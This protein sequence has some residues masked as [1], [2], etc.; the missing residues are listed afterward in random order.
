MDERPFSLLSRAIARS[1]QTYLSLEPIFRNLPGMEESRQVRK[2]SGV[3]GAGIQGS[4]RLGTLLTSLREPNL[5]R[6][7]PPLPAHLHQSPGRPALT[8]AASWPRSG[9]FCLKERNEVSL[10][11]RPSLPWRPQ[12]RSPSSP[13][14]ASAASCPP[15][16]PQ[17]TVSLYIWLDHKRS[18]VQV[19]QLGSPQTLW[20]RRHGGL[21]VC[22]CWSLRRVQLFATPQT[23]GRLLCPWNSPGKS[24]EEGCHFLL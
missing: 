23:V 12:L 7:L 20:R 10:P 18:E 1:S 4:L 8:G 16:R 5:R 3:E 2:G 6:P 22:L 24:T 11:R 14:P 13:P 17:L 19:S 21:C 9:I 15:R